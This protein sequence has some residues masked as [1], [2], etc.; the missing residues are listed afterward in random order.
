VVLVTQI[1][2]GNYNGTRWRDPLSRSRVFSVF[3]LHPLFTSSLS[4]SSLLLSRADD[5]S[6]SSEVC[7][8]LY[9][10]ICNSKNDPT[11]MYTL[12]SD[13]DSLF[14]VKCE[15]GKVLNAIPSSIRNLFLYFCYNRPK[16]SFHSDYL[17]NRHDRLSLPS[18]DGKSVRNMGETS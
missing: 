7:P 12:W 18:S 14:F 13:S 15:T 6:G 11:F 4:S 16:L 9:L 10:D 3:L 5:P 8:S 1:S 2:D 17:R